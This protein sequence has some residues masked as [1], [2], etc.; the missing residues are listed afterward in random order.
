[1]AAS[2]PSAVKSF[3]T[4]SASDTIEADHVNALQDEVVALET[5]ILN[6]FA[7]GLRP[8]ADATYD[9]GTAALQFRDEYLSRFL[10]IG[11]TV[12]TSMTAGDIAH[13]NTK[14]PKGVNAAGT[15]TISL[16]RLNA[17]DQIE[18]GGVDRLVRVGHIAAASLPAASANHNG[19]I[20]VDADNDRLVYYSG[21][22]RYY[23]AT[24]TSF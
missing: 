6:G 20:A 3:T 12:S 23:L 21:G 1:M 13:P 7:H 11:T 5:A 19:A 14:G 2:Y 15:D 16:V 9:L 24:G 10:F 4:K 18:L 8:N 17:Q 22:A